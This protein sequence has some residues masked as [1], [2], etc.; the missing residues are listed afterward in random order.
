MT[1]IR[2]RLVCLLI[3]PLAAI[4]C[5]VALETFYSSKKTSNDLHD[6]TL[7][8][9]MLTISE[10]V[11]ASNG[12]VL[13]ENIL[14][15]LTN[16]L[17]DQFFYH[18]AGP[19]N[20]FVTGYTGGPL[21]PADIELKGGKP[22]F[23]YATYQDNPVR[24]SAIKLLITGQDLNGWV[25]IST[26]QRITR[27]Q[28]LTLELF[29]RSLAR[30][31]LM[32]ISAGVIVWFGVSHGLRPINELR[33]AIEKRS[34]TELTPIKRKMPH[35]L[36]G[37]ITSMNDLLK[38]VAR[39]K[40]NRERFIGDAAHQLR[41]PIAAL[42]TQA[43]TTLQYKSAKDLRAGLERVLETTRQ[44]EKLVEH[45]LASAGI[46]AL[47][48]GAFEQI[49]LAEIVSETSR[50][51]APRALEKSQDFS[52]ELG[53]KTLIIK[54]HRLLLREAVSN[55]ID[56]AVTHSPEGAIIKV[57]L[58]KNEIHEHASIKVADNGASFDQE[59]MSRLSQPFSTGQ[60]TTSGSGLGLA[61]AKEV[62]KAHGGQLIVTSLPEPMA[63]EI[64]LL[65][66]IS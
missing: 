12:T 46:N 52:L 59:E 41:N 44:T 57:S 56:N 21:L 18:V 37:I 53:E 15:V 49:D 34:P 39:S 62:I 50:H 55:L 33:A 9:V 4:A 58:G 27:R 31:F 19:S 30:L 35:E 29:G 43:Q 60:N 40:A 22:E 66:P 45:L 20:A 51:L 36:G 63:K 13:A 7:L 17:G 24:V 47:D 54:G 48:S 14:E 1:S 26:W 61:I 16:N 25:T 5:F 23:F 11:V 38:R 65:L 8:A 32:I 2:T 3:V 42:K 10:N 28:Q 6:K 64:V